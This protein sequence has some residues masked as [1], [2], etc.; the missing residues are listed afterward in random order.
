M[1]L[2]RQPGIT[3]NTAVAEG[4]SSISDASGQLLMY[5]TLDTI[6]DRNGN[7]MPN[8]AG[9]LPAV[10]LTGLGFNSSCDA[11]SL[12][13]QSIND[14]KKYFVFSLTSYSTSALSV[15][16]GS[17]PGAG[18]LYY[19]VVDMNLNGGLGDVVLPGKGHSDRFPAG[20]STGSR[21]RRACNLWVLSMRNNGS[22]IHA[23]E[24]NSTGVNTAPVISVCNTFNG[25]LDMSLYFNSTAGA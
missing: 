7:I 2:Q 6:W 3:S 8:A 14:P 15:L 10:P 5:A 25:T 20:R 17:D 23:F 12:I 9:L 18:K 21:K 13:V 11:Q 24:I 16:P 1:Q 4:T 22:A 19:S